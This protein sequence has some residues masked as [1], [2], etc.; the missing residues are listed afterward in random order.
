[1]LTSPK[2]KKTRVPKKT[3][4]A[5]IM[6]HFQG[7]ARNAALV[8][9]SK[10][11]STIASFSEEKATPG[12]EAITPIAFDLKVNDLSFG[13][14]VDIGSSTD[15]LKTDLKKAAQAETKNVRLPIPSPFI[16]PP[17]KNIQIAL[18]MSLYIKL[19]EGISSILRIS[20]PQQRQVKFHDLIDFFNQLK[21][22]SKQEGAMHLKINGYLGIRGYPVSSAG[23]C[24]GISI[25]IA[26]AFAAHES[27][28][29]I[30]RL[31]FLEQTLFE[32]SE[33]STKFNELFN[34]VIQLQG[35]L[36]IPNNNV[37]ITVEISKINALLKNERTRLNAFLKRTQIKTH[38]DAYST[39][40]DAQNDRIASFQVPDKYPE[41]L[42]DHLRHFDTQT[43]A[44]TVQSLSL[45]RKSI[46]EIL[47]SGSHSAIF[48]LAQ[49]LLANSLNQ[50]GLTLETVLGSGDEKFISKLV[51]PLTLDDVTKT[52]IITKLVE[53]KSV[54]LKDLEQV[55]VSTFGTE[56]GLIEVNRFFFDFTKT[57]SDIKSLGLTDKKEAKSGTLNAFLNVLDT[58]AD[59]F[60]ISDLIMT[61]RSHEH[62]I[63]VCRQAA[64]PPRILE[65]RW[66]FGDPSK[67]LLPLLR[68]AFQP[69][70]ITSE[71]FTSFAANVK[72]FPDERCL[73]S[74]FY[75]TTGQHQ[76]V[77]ALLKELQ[78]TPEFNAARTVSPEKIYIRRNLEA[79]DDIELSQAAFAGIALDFDML[80]AIIDYYFQGND[81]DK[82]NK[83]NSNIGSFIAHAVMSGF[84]FIADELTDQRS[85]FLIKYSGMIFFDS[86]N[87]L[88]LL[89]K[90][91]IELSR[92][93]LSS[94]MIKIFE[95]LVLDRASL[96]IEE[97]RIELL[98][99]ALA[100]LVSVTPI[101]T[102]RLQILTSLLTQGLPR[103]TDSIQKKDIVEHAFIETIRYEI[104]AK[105]DV[106]PVVKLLI[107]N[108]LSQLTDEDDKKVVLKTLIETAFSYKPISP[109][110][111]IIEELISVAKIFLTNP[112][113][114]AELVESAFQKTLSQDDT[115]ECD[116]HQIF[117]MV[118]ANSLELF[119]NELDK[120]SVIMMALNQAIVIPTTPVK[121]KILESL[122][123]SGISS[124]T[125]SEIQKD[126]LLGALKIALTYPFSMDTKPFFEAI[127]KGIEY[128]ADQNR[129][130][131]FIKESIV[132]AGSQE[133]I[134]VS[135]IVDN[136]F[137]FISNPDQQKLILSGALAS[138][139]LSIPKVE[140]EIIDYLSKK[141]SSYE[142]K[143]TDSVVQSVIADGK[144]HKEFSSS[145]P[146][147]K[148]SYANIAAARPFFAS[149]AR[150][151][152]SHNP[153]SKMN[154]KTQL[155]R[156]KK[157]KRK[158]KRK[159]IR[160][161]KS[162]H[163]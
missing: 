36:A 153:D 24:R 15:D 17:D 12:L 117:G 139:N 123:S 143:Q 61:F 9:K 1:M 84:P 137:T 46:S 2:R 151:D 78:T 51:K 13:S 126:I 69:D 156:N 23:V 116:V 16:N 86:K 93:Q 34:T 99:T 96:L 146:K 130:I 91:I 110:Q 44:R 101:D 5:E 67:Q 59:K 30:N 20:D 119:S 138:L 133:L 131:E 71:T 160:K 21:V 80:E 56:T 7:P 39:D 144:D 108:G 47:Q 53:L 129:Q 97:D 103:L 148:K 54:E 111:V 105:R 40:I 163:L 79:K 50:E 88:D 63:T 35:K 62:L 162:F 125:N 76:A 114:R 48:G 136:G 83:I 134:F 90:T 127:M 70:R 102:V 28:I 121:M 14:E 135:Q 52:Q 106:M 109:R 32:F 8:Q 120:K 49:L 37:L 152:T 11:R 45:E 161:N 98:K 33:N 74:S 72:G 65:S 147:T 157:N 150:Q 104:D 58:L 118:F 155:Q 113:D 22:D 87:Q 10:T 38:F 95:F 107:D 26:E 141:L 122:V 68:S 27:D 73:I 25:G 132:N 100:R 4:T 19:L 149:G 94:G 89:Q 128:I 75:T 145:E 6:E 81:V 64:D 85:E 112:D 115:P 18:R 42:Q 154:K 77:K 29:L 124:F 57:A 60:K 66:V 41:A 92:F 55:G 82:I 159:G 31:L 140:T 43:I 158:D 3:H 142:Q